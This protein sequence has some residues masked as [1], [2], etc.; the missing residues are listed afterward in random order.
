MKT[1]VFISKNARVMAEFAI[2]DILRIIKE[3]IDFEN[4]TTE[5]ML[6]LIT[7]HLTEE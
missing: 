1:I 5:E 4:I 3:Y 6:Q 2:E 7:D